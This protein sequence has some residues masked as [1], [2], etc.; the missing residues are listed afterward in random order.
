MQ[1]D[2]GDGPAGRPIQARAGKHDV[3][4]RHHGSRG[5]SVFRYRTDP[6]RGGACAG[7]A[8]RDAGS[9]RRRCGRTRLRPIHDR[10]CRWL[11]GAGRRRRRH[12][13][14]DSGKHGGTG[15]VPRLCPLQA[16]RRTRDGTLVAHRR[17]GS[18]HVRDG[19]CQRRWE[20]Q[21]FPGLPALARAR[22]AAVPRLPCSTAARPILFDRL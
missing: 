16:P 20:D 10:Y 19:G 14:V 5:P 7:F 9:R 1:L 8:H 11:L 2:P 21:R 17:A 22:E 13:A 3:G 4:R 6:R 15:R 12:T 18:A